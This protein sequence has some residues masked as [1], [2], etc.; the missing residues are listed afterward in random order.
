MGERTFSDLVMPGFGDG[1]LR[2]F[3]DCG[4]AIRDFVAFMGS[5]YWKLHFADF[6]DLVCWYFAASKMARSI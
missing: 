6:F 4:Q 1:I 3:L 5:E 2:Q